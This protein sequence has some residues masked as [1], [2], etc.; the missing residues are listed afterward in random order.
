MRIKSKVVVCGLAALAFSLVE[1]NVVV[2][3]IGNLDG[4]LIR[5]FVLTNKPGMS[6]EIMTWGATVL[7]LKT[8][9]RNGK[10]DDVVCGFDKLSDYPTKSPYFGTIVGRYGNRIAKGKFRLGGKT[11][12]LA[13][14]NGVN[15]LH[16]GLKGFD[17]RVWDAEITDNGAE[18]AVRFT[19]VSRS[20]EE[21]YPGT[22]TAQVT[23]RLTANNALK[24]SY[25]VS[26]NQLTVANLTN[27]SYF[28]LAGTEGRDNL[29][30]VLKIY[31][32][33]FTPVDKTLIPT[34]ELKS[35]NGTP[36]DFLKPTSIGARIDMKDQQLEFG[37]GYD[38]NWVLNGKAGELK[39]AVE[40]F[41]PVTG[42]NMKVWT[43]EPGVQFYSGNFLD[44]TLTGKGGKIY[45]PRYAFCLETQHFPDSPNHPA[46]PTTVIT[47]GKTYRSTTIYKFS[48]K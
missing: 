30:H 39:E 17:K 10:F 37:G 14:N 35:V 29:D 22:L 7:S 15:S 48:A 21:G 25:A 8:Q 6:T 27:H 42:R 18:P 40:V 38:H 20:G 5:S 33:R 44:G 26:S 16:G 46:F 36:F 13:I 34:G 12:K 19:Y 9:D 23:Y 1:A 32:D 2:K 28:N 3:S 31:A 41:E 24:I 4:K 47:P 43:T 11:Y 45:P